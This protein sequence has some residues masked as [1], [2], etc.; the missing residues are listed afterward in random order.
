M[1]DIWFVTGGARSGKSCFAEHLAAQTGR[2]VAY[3]ATMEPLDD[4]LRLRVARHQAQRPDDGDADPVEHVEPVRRGEPRHQGQREEQDHQSDDW[5][6]GVENT[7][8]AP[9]ADPEPPAPHVV[10]PP[11]TR[12]ISTLPK[13]P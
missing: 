5:H 2:A 10:G 9:I 11:Q 4:E 7:L 3:V 6:S 13:K 1:G 12:S 8:V